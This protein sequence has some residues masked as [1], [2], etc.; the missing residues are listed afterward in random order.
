[1]KRHDL[2]KKAKDNRELLFWLFLF[3]AAMVWRFGCHAPQALLAVL[4]KYVLFVIALMFIPFM[5]GIAGF[6]KT[7][8][9]WKVT[10]VSLALMAVV[11]EIS[12]HENILRVWYQGEFDQQYISG[13]LQAIIVVPGVF[14]FVGFFLR[15]D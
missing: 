13:L 14:F 12:F 3:I 15:R 11:Y 5:T 1:M 7:K 9:A 2:I 4:F 8:S 10:L 6:A